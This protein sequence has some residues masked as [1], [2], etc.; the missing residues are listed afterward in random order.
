M[1]GSV[2]VLAPDSSM[3]GTMKPLPEVFN[4]TAFTTDHVPL[5]A[6]EDGIGK[7]EAQNGTENGERKIVLGRNIHTMCLEVSEPDIDDE[8][9][10]ERE[11]YMAS[12]LAKYKKSLSE[13]TK[14]HLGLILDLQ[15]FDLQ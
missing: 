5:V 6:R 15:V 14:Y 7:G 1:A 3:N 12:V 4:S 11:A 9:T 10:G 8:V 13:R 2:E